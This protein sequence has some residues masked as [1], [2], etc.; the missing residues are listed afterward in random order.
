MKKVSLAYF[1]YTQEKSQKWMKW[2]LWIIRDSEQGEF[3]RYLCDKLLVLN[4]KSGQRFF[5]WC[6][7]LHGCWTKI[8]WVPNSV[9]TRTDPD[10]RNFNPI[11][12]SIVFDMNRLR[13]EVGVWENALYVVR[14]YQTQWVVCN[15][16]VVFKSLFHCGWHGMKFFHDDKWS[17]RH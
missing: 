14:W 16:H 4:M 6:S 13:N 5:D 12:A 11:Q 9:P 2:S 10:Q 7:V 1:K 15:G 17:C 8:K 3:Y